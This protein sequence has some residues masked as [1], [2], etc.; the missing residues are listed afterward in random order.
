[1]HR[2]I[3]RGTQRRAG[4][5]IWRVSTFVHDGTTISSRQ[6]NHTRI[7]VENLKTALE[8]CERLRPMSVAANDEAC[9]S[10]QQHLT[11][12]RETSLTGV[13]AIRSLVHQ[14]NVGAGIQ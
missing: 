8:L 13:R 7:N 11:N 4:F 3:T 10:F 5:G 12:L 6:D 9:S 2:V 14:Y 1:M